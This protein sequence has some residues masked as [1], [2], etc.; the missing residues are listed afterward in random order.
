MVEPTGAEI[1]VVGRMAGTEVQVS[2]KERHDFTHGQRIYLQ[3]R[4]ELSHIF[5]RE[6]G[7]VLR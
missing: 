4:R 3:P 5:D 1:L 6:S 2:F 7:Q